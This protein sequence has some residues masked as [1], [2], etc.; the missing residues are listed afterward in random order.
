MLQ[1]LGIRGK[2]L[3][4][5]AVPTIVLLLAASFVVLNA[6]A[7]YNAGRNTSQ[8]V[9]SVQTGTPLVVAL[10]EERALVASYL[11]AISDGE[12]D[13]ITSRTNVNTTVAA[14]RKA[15]EDDPSFAPIANAIQAAMDGANGQG[16]IESARAIAVVEPVEEGFPE[17]PDAAEV[18]SVVE[19]F[20]R[21]AQEV[22]A[23]ASAAPANDIGNLAR[24]LAGFVRNEGVTTERYLTDARTAA[25][26][27]PESFTVVDR[28]AGAFADRVDNIANTSGNAL[29][30]E[31]VTDAQQGIADLATLR[32][33]VRQGTVQPGPAQDTYT[34][35]IGQLFGGTREVANTTD[36]RVLAD[37]LTTFVSVGE[38]IE[39]M[40][41]EEVYVTRK[42]AQGYWRLGETVQFQ[43]YYFGSNNALDRATSAVAPLG[44]ITPVPEF[45]ASYSPVERN[46]YE[47]IRDR[48]VSDPTSRALTDQRTAEWELQVDEEVALYSPILAELAS[49]VRD[50][51]ATVERNS[52]VQTIATIAVA[53]LAV[54][55][56]LVTALAIA[57]RIVNPLRRLTTT[58]T[59]VR[60]ELPRLVERVALPGQSVDLSEVQI[61]VESQDEVGR[62]AEAFNSVNAATLAIAAEQA[63][64]R[65]SISEMFVNVARRDQ[66]LLNR[67][68]SSIDEMERTEDN[69]S[70]LTKLF[71]LDHLAT[72]MRRNS[73]SLLVLAGIDT[74]RRLRRSMPLSDVIRTAS[75]EIE[76][77]ERIQLELDADP[78]MLGHSALTAA[79][80]FAELL[81]NA[82]VFSDPGS[83]V[84]VRT[85]A[86]GDNVIVEVRDTGIGMTTQELA[87]ANARVAS[88]AASEIL[89]AQRLGLFVVGRIARRVGARVQLESVEGEGTV[90]RIVMPPSLFDP[91]AAYDH[92][93]QSTSA[94]DEGTHAPAALVH[95]SVAD[96]EER[97]PAPSEAQR[98]VAAPHG[99]Q[100]TVIEEGVSLAGRPVESPTAPRAGETPQVQQ[101]A[102]LDNLV[103]ADAAA[104]PE[105]Q[106]VDLDALTEG[107]TPAG[108]PTRRRKS[109]D[110]AA[111]APQDT[112]SIIGLPMRASDEQLTALESATTS[113]FTPILA[114]DEVSPESA[115]QRSRV[116]RG[117]RPLRG[118]DDGA[119]A[120]APDAESLGHA[121]RRGAPEAD[122]FAS[123]SGSDAEPSSWFEPDATEEQG[124][125][126]AES[127][128]NDPRSEPAQSP[129]P[130]QE[131]SAP[132][133]AVEASDPR[134]TEPAVVRQS[135]LISTGY[136][137]ED[138][139][140]GVSP[141]APSAGAGAIPS[142]AIP[143]LEE[144]EPEPEPVAPAPWE[145]AGVQQSAGVESV[146]LDD[147]P[148]PSAGNQVPAPEA[149]PPM[150]PHGFQT[151]PAPGPAY[152]SPL[153]P[154]MPANGAYPPPA[155]FGQQ[156]AEP[157]HDWQRPPSGQAPVFES[158]PVT[159]TPSL[160]DLILDGAPS[161]GSEGRGG[162]FSRLFG[163]GGKQEERAEA[164]AAAQAPAPATFA[165]QESVGHPHAQQ[166]AYPAPAQPP[167]H[168]PFPS[169]GA[170]Q[171]APAAASSEE[172]PQPAPFTSEA[173][174]PARE[175][176]RQ[177]EDNSM[178]IGGAPQANPSSWEA[179]SSAPVAPPTPHADP[180]SVP[181]AFI[182]DPTRNETFEAEWSMPGHVAAPI[183]AVA[184]PAFAPDSGRAGPMAYSPDQLA[185]PMGWEAAGE[186]AL[187]AAAPE[188]A[189][190]YRPVVQID[191]QPVGEGFA[192]FSS[193][194]FSELS[195]LASKRP[196]VEKTQAGLVKRTPVERSTEPEPVAEVAA[197]EVP[198]DADAVRNRF[199]S[200]YS[201]TQRAR[202]D[203]K[204]FNDSTQGSLTEP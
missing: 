47:T 163:K 159:S 201:G 185:R 188:A 158:D 196:K 179:P 152:R 137:E 180:P 204:N 88:T 156:V 57:R 6:A 101:T 97:D 71:A 86:E 93:H 175:D 182:P 130:R 102:A 133:F 194:V 25:E 136:V 34:G 62:L 65:G 53:A 39:A 200:F 2:L 56:S 155:P 22:T 21:I 198:R 160:D 123:P 107:V 161:S 168:T 186:S 87:E 202:D 128:E 35:I 94:V 105:A 145:Q 98:P 177:P 27:L 150:Q 106:A 46:G 174:P 139:D 85:M 17:W 49:A 70:T 59:A 54:I 117:F 31:Y 203:V 5:V 135:P 77:Y 148:Y 32:E 51:A 181:T 151:P 30:L 109:A 113:G 11:R 115:E 187:Q 189:T 111:E 66:V 42:I 63:A 120:L 195:S 79:H 131:P 12:A 48:L 122:V 23:I 15:G 173:Q 121:V 190:E 124:V 108:L 92:S 44:D 60:Q 18:D 104:A 95:H 74:G 91:N 167:A 166:M 38:L 24:T 9:E 67:Q 84:V 144:D 50:R 10:Q 28:T 7:T 193:E 43:A 176:T 40:R 162:F 52:L 13:R 116:F 75:S 199:S 119:P 68:L 55:A 80:L 164:P 170:W 14:L 129:E 132:P 197:P 1:R 143:M 103:A 100:P 29:I 138:A 154:S 20:D 99:Y 141:F 192:D 64:L 72:R 171:T 127:E 140:A 61:P 76:L 37:Y 118:D 147:A 36:D 19:V 142:M 178:W 149:A 33:T 112:N 169:S 134:H 157:Q 78:S 146:A 16:G 45:G 26:A 81:E 90:A 153:Y 58:A 184:P 83:P 114:A 73:E 191:P 126:P 96:A 4:V 89:G 110:A 3:A 172:R 82:T 41:L 8:L 183:P 125:A 165:V 69:Q